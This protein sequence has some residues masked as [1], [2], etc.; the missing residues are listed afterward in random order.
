M[1]T[2]P[3]RVAAPFLLAVTG[4]LFIIGLLL[5]RAG[6]AA[7]GIYVV[8]VLGALLAGGIA[9]RRQVRLAA[10]SAR[11]TCTCCAGTVH[12]PVKVI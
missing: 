1:K 9:A 10:M 6:P 8:V 12:D 2:V 4:V 5:R 7:V 11:R 3:G